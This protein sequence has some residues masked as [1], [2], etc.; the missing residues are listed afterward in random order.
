MSI[1]LKRACAAFLLFS[2]A[3]ST[4]VDPTNAYDPGT[5]TGQKAKAHVHGTI[6]SAALTPP[7]SVQVALSTN[8][9]PY[10]QATTAADGSFSFAELPPGSY[11]LQASPDGFVP[12]TLPLTLQPGDQ[13]ELGK[14][15]LT[16]QSGQQLATLT[17]KATLGSAPDS[18]GIL[19]AT[20]ERAFSTQS[21]SSGNWSM[22]VTQGT[23]T[24][25][26]SHKDFLATSVSNVTVQQGVT[27]TLDPV[28]LLLNPAKVKGHVD[29]EL[30]AGGSAPLDQAT[31]T[32]DSTGITGLTD[33]NGD[34]TLTNIPAG[35]YIVR[36]LKA[37]YQAAT[38][39]A[40]NL[41][42]G[43][44]RTQGAP[45]ALQLARGGVKGAVSLSD[46]PS[47]ASGVLI[48]LKGASTANLT[49][50]PDGAF[51]FANLLTGVYQIDASRAGYHPLLL[52]AALTVIEN[53]V[54][55]VASAALQPNPGSVSGHVDGELTSGGS[56]FLPLATVS[57]DGLSGAIVSTD[58]TGNFT[59]KGV[60]VGS[61]VV[62]V[63]ALGYDPQTQPLLNLAGGEARL[64]KAPF[65]L[66]LSRGGISGTLALVDNPADASGVLIQLA[67]GA[68]T[69]SILTGPDG[70]YS[71]NGLLTGVYSV[72][73]SK[74]GYQPLTVQAVVTV[75]AN[76]VTQHVDAPLQ[77]Y[78]ATILGHVTAENT[79]GGVDALQTA[80]VT[81]D[82]A[83]GTTQTGVSGD[84]TLPVPAGSYVVRVHKDGY[85]DATQ[86]VLNL[87]GGEQRTLPN[88][89]SLTLLRGSIAGN[90]KLPDTADASGIIVE[91]TGTASALVTGQSGDYRFDNL[92]AR[93][94]QVTARHD[95]YQRKVLAAAVQ[96]NGTGVTNLP[97]ATLD[98]Q[99]GAVTITPYTK[100]RTVQLSL[101]AP[102]ADH[103]LVSE[104]QN[105]ADASL[106]DVSGTTPPTAFGGTGTASFTLSGADG[107][108]DLFVMFLAAGVPAPL[109]SAQTVLD[110]LAPSAPSVVVNSGS[111]YTN[112]PGGI[113][114]LTLNA[115]DAPPSATP[116]AAVSGLGQMRLAN[117]STSVLT[118]TAVQFNRSTTWSLDTPANQGTKTVC[119]VFI[120]NAS[121]ESAPACTSVVYDTIPPGSAS[122][123]LAGWAASAAHF[124]DSSIITVTLGATDASS[125]G[126][127]NPNLLVQLSNT[128]GF[129]GATFQPFQPSLTWL[130]PPGDG[131][132]TVYAQFL[133][134]AG[135][136]STVVS[137]TLTLDTIAPASPRIT[138]TET[139]SRP[140]NGYT[141]NASITL[142]LSVA[143]EPQAANV[144]ALFSEDPSFTGASAVSIASGVTVQKPLVLGGTGTRTVYARFFDLAG[145]AS[146]TV[147]AGVVVDQTPPD[148]TVLPRLSPSGAANSGAMTLIAPAAGQDELQIAG[149]GVSFTAPAP[150]VTAPA[151]AS[152]PFSLN[153][154]TE[155]SKAIAVQYRDLA[156]NTAGPI[157]LSIV[158]DQ[159]APQTKP[160]VVTG[161]LADGS[162][163]AALTATTA[164]TLDL[165]HQSDALSGIVAMKIS[166]T[167]GLA[168]ANWQPFIGSS[169][170]PWT[171]APGDGNKT[172]YVAL[173][174]A[175]GNDNS[176]SP[177][178]GA[179]ALRTMAPGSPSI[180]LASLNVNS[181]PGYSDSST[182][183]A[184]VNAANGP[185]SVTVSESPGFA[186]GPTTQSI[187]LG[188]KTLPYTFST[189]LG[190]PGARI[191]YAR[192]YD[193]ALNYTP[194]ISASLT[195]DTTF[196]AQLPPT[197][198]PAGATAVTA[199]Q[200]VPPSAGEDFIQLSGAA[201]VTPTGFV[202]A[203]P[204]APLNV[205]LSTGDGL[206]S[207]TVAY[208]DLAGNTTT[209]AA[210]VTVS[211]ETAPPAATNFTVTGTDGDGVHRAGH[212]AVPTVTLGFQAEQDTVSGLPL[213]R[214]GF[215]SDVSDG[216]WQ[217]YAA[218][219]Q[220]ALPSP[221]G[222]KIVY[223]QFQNGVGK[224]S[225]IVQGS[226]A[227]DTTATVK[228]S[229]LL[230]GVAG[231]LAGTTALVSG[232]AL[233]TLTAAD[234]SF[235]L[236][237][238]PSTTQTIVLQRTGYGSQTV[239]L[240]LPAGA[241]VTLPQA[242]LPLS[243]GTV[244]GVIVATG[245]A[246]A[247][248]TQVQLSGTSFLAATDAQG[249]FNLGAVPVG[250]YT[251]V[252]SRTGYTTYSSP[253]PF[254][255]TAGG[256]SALSTAGSPIALALDKTGTVAGTCT[257]PGAPDQN[258]SAITLSGA[259]LNGTSVNGSALT[260]NGAFTVSNLP[261][262]TYWLGCARAGF[263]AGS[264][265]PLALK[266]AQQATGAAFTLSVGTTSLSG[267]VTLSA[268][269]LAG[270]TPGSDFSGV[271]VTVTAGTQAFTTTSGAGGAF[272]FA[273]I[274]FSVS[275]ATYPLVASKP[276]YLSASASVSAAPPGPPTPASLS[277][278]GAP[279]T[280][281]G[282]ITVPAP[283]AD[284]SGVAVQL[285]GTAFSQTAFA[286]SGTT[287]AGGAY[288]LASVPAGSYT[289]TCTRAGYVVATGLVTVPNPPPAGGAPS[290]AGPNATLVRA[291]GAIG[292]TVA[293]GDGQTGLTPDKSGALVAV[294]SSNSDLAGGT[295]QTLT[296]S[297]GSFSLA[298]IP[299][300]PSNTAYA[301]TVSKT[302]YTATAGTS[303]VTVQANAVTPVPAGLSLAISAG[304]LAGAVQVPAPA[305]NPA[306][307]AVTLS[308]SAFNGAAFS[309]G[310]AILTNAAGA[311]SFAHLPPGV[312][313]LQFTL[314]A[315]APA[316][317][318]G[319]VIA[320]GVNTAATVVMSRATGSLAGHIATS[321][322]GTGL[323][324]GAADAAGAVISITGAGL[325][326]SFGVSTDA[327][328]N[329]QVAGIP[330]SLTGS[331]YVVSLS[332]P[333]YL[334]AASS[335]SVTA[336]STVT[337]ADIPLAVAPITANGAVV[338]PAPAADSNGV[339]VALTGTP[340]NGSTFTP[341]PLSSAGGGLYTFSALPAG[342]YSLTL[343]RTGYQPLTTPLLV[344][345][346]PGTGAA[347]AQTIPSVTLSRATGAV[348]GTIVFSTGGTLAALAPSDLAGALVSITQAGSDLTGTG[349][350]VT[351]TDASG[352]FSL[353]GIPVSPTA[354][355]YTATVSKANFV[356]GASASTTLIAGQSVTVNGLSL[357]VNATSLPVT[358]E[359]HDFAGCGGCTQVGFGS[360]AVSVSGT[361]FDGQAVSPSAQ[362]TNGSGL[363]NFAA[364]PPGTYAV[365]ATFAG[366]SS[367]SLGGFSLV[368]GQATPITL[369][370]FDTQAPTTPVITSAQRSPTSSAAATISLSQP[371]TDPTQ[372]TPNFAP[373][374]ATALGAYQWRVCSPG[375]TAF[376]AWTFATSLTVPL[377]SGVD[378]NLFVQA[379]DAAGNV[380]A[381]ALLV[382]HRETQLPN[383]A[384]SLHVDNR[385][386]SARLSWTAPT[387]NNGSS[388][389]NPTGYRVYYGPVYSTNLAD[390]TGTFAAEGSSPIDVGARTELVLDGLANASPF[391]AVVIPYDAVVD[392]GPNLAT[393][394][395]SQIVVVSPDGVPFDF[396]GR[397]SIANGANSF[398]VQRDVVF[399]SSGTTPNYTVTSYAYTGYGPMAPLGSIAG[400]KAAKNLV[401]DDNDTIL[402]YDPAVNGLEVIETSDPV[403][404]NLLPR[405]PATAQSI[406]FQKIFPVHRTMSDGASHSVAIYTSGANT[407]AATMWWA[408]ADHRVPYNYGLDN[409]A[410][411]LS[412]SSTFAQVSW[413]YLVTEGGGQSL[414]V[415]Y[416]DSNLANAISFARFFSVTS[417]S[418]CGTMGTIALDWPNI[419]AAC[420]IGASGLF[421]TVAS[422]SVTT[423]NVP[424][425]QRLTVPVQH[426]INQ[427]IVVGDT[428][429]A[430]ENQGH[431]RA[432]VE[433]FTGLAGSNWVSTTPP[434]LVSSGSYSLQK[435]DDLNGAASNTPA[436]Q[437]S[438]TNLFAFL[439]SSPAGTAAAIDVAELGGPR[440]IVQAAVL[441]AVLANAGSYSY[442]AAAIRGSQVIAAGKSTLGA[443]ILQV[444]LH[445]QFASGTPVSL[446]QNV[447]CAGAGCGP[448]VVNGDYAYLADTATTIQ[449]VDLTPPAWPFGGAVNTTT[450][451]ASGTITGLAVA[452]D[453]LL[454]SVTGASAPYLE[455]W[456]IQNRKSPTELA[457]LPNAGKFQGRGLDV[458]GRFAYVGTS[459]GLC[460]VDFLSVADTLSLAVCNNSQQAF[461][462]S[463]GA[464]TKSGN[465]Y[466]ARIVAVTN[467]GA[468]NLPTT[469]ALYTFD[470][471]TR[472]LSVSAATFGQ[473]ATPGPLLR[474]GPFLYQL[475]TTAT[476]LKF[477]PPFLGYDL[478]GTLPVIAGSFTNLQSPQASPFGLA[479]PLVVVP[480]AT[481]G[482]ILLRL[483]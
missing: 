280:L 434:T 389:P 349:P 139:D 213:M 196:P 324:L 475:D 91:I 133:D 295:Y 337:L 230:E 16:A 57:L 179:I 97:S 92:L 380:G 466:L 398:V 323:S 470:P 88:L 174:D 308:G 231:S 180:S 43:E 355:S 301:V 279:S 98:K 32:L 129:I 390:Y 416:I 365:T 298:N 197:L 151:G 289:L 478:S 373:A 118:A 14:V 469:N 461:Q 393:A 239:Q 25:R 80:S 105:F 367:A 150:F 309:S 304:S 73:A 206:K 317:L 79:S 18:S 326:S 72:N 275:G 40:L 221:D 94:Y 417:G 334:T 155:G 160:F 359:L 345:I 28:G 22:Q 446:N 8:N 140:A 93:V 348:S 423:P 476:G 232:T 24:V 53:E 391:Y 255:V 300:S 342:T 366:H 171:L 459:G 23:Y 374:A 205:T 401:A 84:F 462:V 209:L 291:T 21:D 170:L 66:T 412:G 243:R 325:T 482:L 47:D 86:P 111:G 224:L 29:A 76:A 236:A 442:T 149:A 41:Q 138:L 363:A 199:I 184:T 402:G 148:A 113:V 102:K 159:T 322:N 263:A 245:A 290:V 254:T 120:D 67:G 306:N 175:A 44:L 443:A 437:I 274:P 10:A 144:T 266:P 89:F 244:T 277:L 376:S 438:G 356:A 321:A 335:G 125:G 87:A 162:A 183:N 339:G 449:I 48:V 463:A 320:A 216:T 74:A 249:N 189:A 176:A 1:H 110:R 168:D 479:G 282:I 454:A 186:A 218:A 302:S 49:T 388:F 406:S 270:F 34:F 425:M 299:V 413:P 296:D 147:S 381:P 269:G 223:A 407:Y 15:T 360:V 294:T 409:N 368:A 448:F 457:L 327:S 75:A 451:T 233:T 126:A 419:Y 259:D 78:P 450:I 71:F 315:F 202:P 190:G 30:P 9:A 27:M 26:F 465:D 429:Y 240:P 420:S 104:D 61:Y 329:W 369:K 12:L 336:G 226:V 58:P 477:A 96:V 198:L 142:N 452:N 276:G 54:T 265:G 405:V 436:V 379:L 268:G 117:D 178:T 424:D 347:G 331:S 287:N 330:V 207:I 225:N 313:T 333:G 143:P 37:G 328:G 204:G 307:V 100:S 99:G 358:A 132:K 418:G 362:L 460:V 60:P 103:Y 435:A 116:G 377:T 112:A 135:N 272:S 414:D 396:A 316:S 119:A 229:V 361:A 220:V 371:S 250:S 165:S 283:A 146:P 246:T 311:Y 210:P 343:S 241:I 481:E 59:I 172:V 447:G 281:A 247:A 354:A 65:T 382:L 161:A 51:S 38:Q 439:Q 385:P 211:L 63:S 256:T 95:G 319:V 312:Y 428:L 372:P 62:R 173:Q 422:G 397:T 480:D 194:S 400:L 4:S 107:L 262:G 195:V 17:G 69:G 394:A 408:A 297:S 474:S 238:V 264:Y 164:V 115:L 235:T 108:H 483:F 157:A 35:S 13:V 237:S 310:A 234:G 81:L 31:V 285:S 441:P 145:N 286:A 121:N 136:P 350:W 6:V 353:A 83:G 5:P 344:P 453:Y 52:Q 64:L 472:L 123:A 415:Y 227:L 152:I 346:P 42:G 392:P 19:I 128:P 257:A 55:Q 163:S 242:T 2:A 124:T 471:K 387:A 421:W 39:P 370:L 273:A 340:F 252:A 278:G 182:V 141:N 33:A 440:S 222:A 68:S 455:V 314:T 445:T 248:G 410:V 253:S 378:N 101:N 154:A 130:L 185:V 386:G 395:S 467:G 403:N 208:R 109:S 305:A 426:P 122:I 399:V 444:D 193:A 201:I 156:D 50:G 375:C 167:A 433:A 260:A 169:K 383:P 219:P 427:L 187:S 357:A 85:A 404:L 90:V 82:G 177:S 70:K 200:L 284:S 192:F 261:A 430:A 56:A 267:T 20:V 158:Y 456:N 258:N 191:L 341:S 432:A 181:Q 46:N 351:T 214:F 303:S 271:A 203:T 217:P 7:L 473:F 134:P 137:D 188:G 338:V 468:G 45:F 364:L 384:Q 288:S 318:S 153:T 3:C 127:G 292:G 251:A 431:G 212:T 36:A 215:A 114:S 166:N 458:Q 106:G 293:F 464:G 411:Q 332:K 131:P 11:A 352:A 228:G 77:P